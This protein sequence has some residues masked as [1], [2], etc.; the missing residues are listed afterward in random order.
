MNSRVQY[1]N[2]IKH[3]ERNN[4]SLTDRLEVLHLLL[5]SQP[6]FASY[7]SRNCSLDPRLK[8]RSK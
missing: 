6:L 1:K 7:L 8:Q 2:Y 3:I 4:D 5:L